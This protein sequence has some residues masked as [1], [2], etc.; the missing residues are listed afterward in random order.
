VDVLQIAREK[1]MLKRLQAGREVQPPFPHA[2][3]FEISK[4]V[5]LEIEKRVM[6]LRAVQK[7]VAHWQSVRSTIEPWAYRKS[8][9]VAD[10]FLAE[11][12]KQKQVLLRVEDEIIDK[13]YE[14]AKIQNARL[15]KGEPA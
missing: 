13:N 7:K 5:K 15:R 3:L 10:D 14:K 11:N 8:E 12:Q 1:V 6:N 2:E 9:Q 4:F